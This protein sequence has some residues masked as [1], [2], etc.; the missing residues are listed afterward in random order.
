MTSKN[1]ADSASQDPHHRTMTP[2]SVEQESH[3]EENQDGETSRLI[4]EERRIVTGNDG[5]FS[6]LAAKPD[7]EIKDEEMPPT[8]EA[9][10]ADAPP[11]FEYETTIFTTADS[12]EILV[13]GMPV[14]SIFS[15]LWNMLISACFQF[16]GFILTYLLHMTHAAKNG[17]KT[18]LGLTLMHL[19][20]SLRQR[21]LN[22]N[23]NFGDDDE[24]MLYPTN[25]TSPT[26]MTMSSFIAWM[27]M[28]L[29]WFITVRSIFAYIQALRTER[30]I[31]T[32]PSPAEIY[33]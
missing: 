13:E 3:E 23:A 7:L 30:I 33:V 26:E 18:G 12:D 27:L 19:G 15:F 32:S 14:G 31:Q 24:D 9:A 5:V 4:K 29:G 1:D 8:Y 25:P 22:P 11:P 17:S 28:A 2:Q 20:F 6:N 16:V 10:A 21:V